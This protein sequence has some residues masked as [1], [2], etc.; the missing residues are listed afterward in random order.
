M[1]IQDP[2]YQTIISSQSKIKDDF[3]GIEDSLRAIAKRQISVASAIK[4]N[5]SV[6]SFSRGIGYFAATYI[7]SKCTCYIAGMTGGSKGVLIMSEGF[8]YKKIYNLGLY[9]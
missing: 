2:K 5:V 4:K 9:E 3:K 1:Y 8:E 7:L 6:D